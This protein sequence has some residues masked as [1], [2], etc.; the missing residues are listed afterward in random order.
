VGYAWPRP[1]NNRWLALKS[2]AEINSII[3]RSSS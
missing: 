2:D 1:W 3:I